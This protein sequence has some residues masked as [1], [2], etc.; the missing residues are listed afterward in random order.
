MGFTLRKKQQDIAP[1]YVN[2]IGSILFWHP[3]LFSSSGNTVVAPSDSVQLSVEWVFCDGRNLLHSKRT[4]DSPLINGGYSHVPDLTDDR[5]LLGSFSKYGAVN[6]AGPPIAGGN[7]GDNTITI[8]EPALPPHVHDRGSLQI[9]SVSSSTQIA[10]LHGH[11]YSFANHFNVHGTYGGPVPVQPV[12]DY[13]TSTDPQSQ[14][15]EHT[16]NIN[17]VNISGAFSNGG[18]LNSPISIIPKYL[19]GKFIIRVK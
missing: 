11:T 17:S 19:S 10:P 15:H 4:A 6:H 1:E 12:S 14:Y 9:N 7:N 3:R 16:F 13:Y 8:T 2:P 18:F 5:F